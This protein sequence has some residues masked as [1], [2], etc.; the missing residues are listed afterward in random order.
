[1]PAS[2]ELWHQQFGHTAMQTIKD[3]DEKQQVDGIKLK[4]KVDQLYDCVPCS[5]AKMR[6]MSYGRRTEYASRPLQRISVD[7]CKASD[8]TV[9]NVSTAG[10]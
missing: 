2:K 4:K 3:M 8:K 6:R 10:R 5:V 1:M 9:V 7:I